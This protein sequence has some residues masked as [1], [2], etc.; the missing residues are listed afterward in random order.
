MAHRELKERYMKIHLAPSVTGRKII[1]ETLPSILLH[2]S[3][4]HLDP[5]KSL[6][7]NAFP[8]KLL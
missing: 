3:P 8:E 4:L 2:N 5:Q 6:Q 1:G 7:A